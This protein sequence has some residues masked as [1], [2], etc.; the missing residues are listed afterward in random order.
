MTS[1]FLFP[2]FPLFPSPLTFDPMG[3][4]G[5]RVV[6][7]PNMFKVEHR[8]FRFPRS[9]RKRIRQKWAKNQRNWRTTH[10]PQARIVGTTILAH[11]AVIASLQHFIRTSGGTTW[12]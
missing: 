8:Q 6:S 12:L 7:D 1:P 3:G 11:P 5:M 2:A 10:V 9:K 4:T